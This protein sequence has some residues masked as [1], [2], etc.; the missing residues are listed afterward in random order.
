M[1][2]A[3]A[4]VLAV[5]AII[6]SGCATTDDALD[7]DGL[8]G[9]TD[10]VGDSAS[11]LTSGRPDGSNS[12]KLGNLGEQKASS[13]GSKDAVFDLGRDPQLPA[14][15]RPIPVETSDSGKRVSFAFVDA[16]IQEFVRVA[17]DEI[18]KENV[19]IDPQVQGKVTLR[20]PEPVSKAT[21]LEMIEEVLSINNA[22]MRRGNGV[23]RITQRGAASGQGRVATRIIPIKNIDAEQA[24]LALQPL[25][26]DGAQITA[27]RE[28]RFL[29]IAGSPQ[30]IDSL[31]GFVDA[32]D[33]DQ[34]RGMSLGLV[35][36]K[37]AGAKAVSSELNQMFG[38][39]SGFRAVAVDRMNAVLITASSKQVIRRATTWIQ[40]L[41][42]ANRDGRQVFV[43]PIRNRKAADVAAVLS[44][45]LGITSTGSQPS[46]QG[47]NPALTPQLSQVAETGQGLQG[48]Y[49]PPG[50]QPGPLSQLPDGGSAE[51]ALSTID[52]TLNTPGT[53]QG[54]GI[55][56]RADA[57]TNS[58]VIHATAE[59][60]RSVEAAIRSLDVLPAQVLIEATIMEVSLNDALRHGVRW[61][62]ESGNFGANLSDDLG[63]AVAN[64]NPGLNIAYGVSNARVV[65]N[66][67]EGVT[68]VQI[69]SSPALTVLDNQTATLKV[70]DQVPIATRSAV[71][72]SNPDSPIV[73]DIE[74]KDTGVILSVTPRINPSGL[75][76]LDISQEASDVVP[77]TSSDINSPTIRQRKINSTVAV[78]SGNEIILGGIIT[79]RKGRESQ[80]VPVLKDVP[81]IGNLF[82][83]RAARE[84][85]RTE[86]V[87]IIRPTVMANSAE[88]YAVTQEIKAKLGASR[89]KQ[90]QPL[91][92]S[93]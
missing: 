80:G 57:G 76:L 39:A 91:K 28:G 41:D 27:S 29:S 82:T 66:A 83:T 18:L 53:G 90:K 23:V 30:S 87:V 55:E 64:V 71:G 60:Y 9:G 52:N 45:M 6:L 19:V 49:T 65:V 4:W 70:G 43:E 15:G 47:I 86:L 54:S 73:N 37:D 26:T 11:N 58:L 67:L 77:T 59:E 17:F 36:L 33:V 51:S 75:V 63:G 46:G 14:N 81:A 35:P 79:A 7:D 92:R 42:V 24:K 38:R 93:F 3:A 61:F 20:T 12:R 5:F 8:F 74:L 68:Q 88:V 50:G 32:I 1:S 10:W 16:D 25:A 31:A 2:S 21:A 85:A 44:G 48:S 22:E 72:T 84:R 62:L 78:Q 13:A 89:I 40:E 69:V 34:M 56:I